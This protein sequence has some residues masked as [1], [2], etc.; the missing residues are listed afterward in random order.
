[1]IS[2]PCDEMLYTWLIVLF[3]QDTIAQLSSKVDNLKIEVAQ[4]RKALPSQLDNREGM[5]MF[6]RLDS[7]RNTKALE[8][9]LETKR[10]AIYIYTTRKIRT[11]QLI[12]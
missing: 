3:L 9:A 7:E 5:I 12:D 4:L 8:V 6:T 2:L 10:Y 11:S 1:M